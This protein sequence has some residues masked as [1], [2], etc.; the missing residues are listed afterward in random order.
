MAIFSRFQSLIIRG[1]IIGI[2]TAVFIAITPDPRQLIF[3]AVCFLAGIVASYTSSIPRAGLTAAIAVAL[4]FFP[5]IQNSP[6]A[7]LDVLV[8]LAVA[9]SWR[10]TQ[11]TERPCGKE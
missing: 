5:S 6:L 3:T 10:L 11:R 8:F 9:I 4:P 7:V 2:T 1:A